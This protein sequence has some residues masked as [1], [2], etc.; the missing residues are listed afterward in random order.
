M[1]LIKKAPPEILPENV[2]AIFGS[3]AAI[4]RVIDYIRSEATAMAYDVRTAEGRKGMKS[5]AYQVARSKVF[6][7]KGRKGLVS[8]MKTELRL[9]DGRGK[10]LR[11]SLDK[12]RDE[13]K[14]PV[15]AY[16]LEK[17]REKERQE[18]E[19]K[20]EALAAEIERA[21]EEALAM[22]EITDEKLQL[23]KE[24][25]DLEVKA[26]ELQRQREI[27]LEAEARARSLVEEERERAV[28]A[29]M[30][31]KNTADRLKAMEA[32]LEAEL[33]AERAKAEKEREA[34]AYEKDAIFQAI[35][36]EKKTPQEM[37][38]A[39]AKVRE[40]TSEKTTAVGVE[41]ASEIARHDSI[42]DSES[43]PDDIVKAKVQG[44]ITRAL[45]DFGFSEVVAIAVVKTITLPG[46]IP[47]VR[48]DYKSE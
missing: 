41:A 37:A 7:E 47:H 29:K 22:N 44:A 6:L 28:A 33:E 39:E 32:E 2:S 20:R 43:E 24:K 1:E 46:A 26:K 16:E 48:I 5:M 21:H 12:L 38:E 4:D 35:E 15:I 19:K 30:A 14:A 27:D 31:E 23:W 9:I 17:E 40:D 11:D 13:I 45:I 34:F 3:D 42:D 25:R 36:K 8:G 10:L 18:A